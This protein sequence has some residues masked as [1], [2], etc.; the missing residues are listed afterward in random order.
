MGVIYAGALYFK[1]RFNR[2][3]GSRLAGLLGALRF[4]AVTIIAFF[5]LKPLIRSVNST[6]E[7]P[8]IVL[9]QDNSASIIVGNDSSFYT[10]EYLSQLQA[11][12]TKLEAKYDVQAFSFGDHVKNGIDSISFEDQITDYSNL[13]EEINTRFTGRNL[14]AIV[15]ASDGIYNKG[16]NPLYAYNALKAPI[17][18][19]ALGDS[20]VKKDALISNVAANRLAYLNN[21][22]P[23]VI[24]AEGKKANGESAVVEV[25]HKGNTIFSQTVSFDSE[26][27]LKTIE[28]T[29]EA[30]T[31]GL[32]KYS[33]SI[34]SL[35]NEVTYANNRKDIFIDVLDSRQK[36]LIL[37]A[38]PHPDINA[39]R[40]AVTNNDAYSVTTS[41][42]SQFNGRLEEYNLII[43]HQLPAA[44]QNGLSQIIN[45]LDKEIPSL[46]IWGGNTDFRAFNDLQ[47][48]FQLTDFRNLNTEVNPRLVEDFPV[49]NL[50]DE[51]K[52][53][54][55]TSPPLAI[56][57]GSIKVSPAT[58]V[59]IAQ[60][61]GQ[62]NTD[63]PLIAFSKKKD[64]K[65][66]WIGGEGIWRWRLNAYRQ[67]ETHEVFDGMLTKMIQYMASKDDKSLFRVNGANNFPENA[68]V[69]FDAE[70]YNSSFEPIAE[71]DI[72]IVFKNE[73]GDEF[74]YTFSYSN[75]R[76][77]LNAG[78][79][80][81]GNYTYKASVVSEGQTLKE[82]GEFSVIELQVEL[83]N[84]IADFKLLKQLAEDHGGE[85][86]DKSNLQKLEELLDSNQNIN[87]VLYENKQLDDL[88]NFRW[89]LAI[90]L[91]L[92]GM[93]WLLRKRAGTY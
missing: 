57:L 5:L 90:I 28:L 37:A 17:Y 53:L 59:F 47:V 86:I 30:K 8:I 81:V 11:L 77:K 14:G 4:A 80:P 12:K 73:N 2:T 24:N 79:L 23:L 58:Q 63:K 87:T 35:K 65:I 56:P 7:K 45:A 39:I 82:T 26:K 19:I 29:L 32:Q 42:I 22:F 27:S 50:E 40:E 9:A 55:N 33:I 62:I 91:G 43:F 84:T 21:K 69:L 31:V 61:V 51:Y 46:F 93:E 13:L 60:K 10:S 76:Y 15:I 71:K 70:L 38:A 48:G 54:I 49:F 74:N 92:L 75:G 72:A 64:T 16:S 20:V 52:Q 18:T 88:I 36:I 85:M 66:G 41:L 83:T 3:Y 78:N 89:L 44:G 1:D 25:T 67:F 68:P 6:E 34:S